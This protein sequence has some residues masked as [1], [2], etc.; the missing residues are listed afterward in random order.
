MIVDKDKL[1][2][3]VEGWKDEKIVLV[4]GVFDILHAGHISLLRYAKSIGSI[5]VVAV[6]SDS[7]TRRLK[8]PGK[9]YNVNREMIVD[10]IVYV[11]YTIVFNEDTPSDIIEILEPDVIVK[12]EEYRGKSIP[13]D[14]LRGRMK[15]NIVY[16]PNYTTGGKVMSDTLL[17]NRIYN[18]TRW[19]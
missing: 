4:N 19:R 12:G 3:L 11:D 10:S 7:S 15:F 6:N 8:G 16:A 9:P 13:E 14:A 5:L 17:A 18:D 1:R 2:S